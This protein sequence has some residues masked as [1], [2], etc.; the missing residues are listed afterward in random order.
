MDKRRTTVIL[1]GAVALL[2]TIIL[3]SSLTFTIHPGERGI[4]FH[5]F[6]GGLDRDHVYGQGFHVKWPWDR[7]FIYDV[8]IKEDSGTMQ[9]L[10]KNGLTIRTDLSYRYKAMD[11]RIGYLH[12]IIGP[13]YHQRIV[14]PEIRSATREVIG[15][16]LPE[17]LYST[18]R[19]AIQEEIFERTRANLAEKDILL[20]AVLIREVELPV[21]LQEAIERKLEQ[22]QAA[23]E[24]EFK[25]ERARKEAERQKIEAEGKATANN[26][27]NA[28]LSDKILREKGIEATLKLAQSDNAKVVVV[29]SGED[30]LPIILGNQQT[31]GPEV[32]L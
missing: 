6:G 2:T 1:V 11:E 20:D 24:Y 31:S 5:T 32:R 19:E 13:T 26:I 21:K 18:Q 7:V 30:G 16:Y 23:L 12:D 3:W 15:K 27:I 17:E 29:G 8:K 10:S 14:L 25:L 4:V 28:S 9:V 22:E